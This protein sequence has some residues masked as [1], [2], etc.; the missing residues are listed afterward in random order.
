V[1]VW[2]EK[3]KALE[4]AGKIRVVGIIQEQHPDRCALFMQ[5]H[6]MD[7]PIMVDSLD[8]LETSAVPV[9][10][11]ID[12]A[13]VVYK[14]R[15]RPRDLEAFLSEPPVEF[16]P[17]EPAAKSD[18]DALRRGASSGGVPEM[19]RYADA[20]YLWGG[21]GQIDTAI[22]MYNQ[23][24]AQSD[25]A[26]TQ[27]H[28]GVALLTRF[29]AAGD[30]AD[31]AAAVAHWAAALAMNPN[32]YIWRRRIQQYGP[33]LDKPYSF[34]DWVSRARDEISA[35]GEIPRPLSREPR[36]AELAYPSK[37][38]VSDET[39]APDP[40]PDA[41]INLD[42]RGLIDIDTIVVPTTQAGGSSSRIHVL[43]TPSERLKAHWNNEVDGV[44]VWLNPPQG[45]ELSSQTRVLENPPQEVSREVRT[46]EFEARLDADVLE[47]ATEVTIPGYVLYYVCEDM[48]GECLYLRQAFEVKV[49]VR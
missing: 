41:S 32:Q 46:A 40:D 5:W 37:K 34:Y 39:A 8:L 4:Q 6:E 31:F 25:D 17:V 7:W 13:G 36:G 9:T 15:A 49:P 38:F 28:L 27:F 29:E 12:E 10:V 23:L 18:L 3:T 11:L 22:A 26:T 30:P 1:P 44:Q 14:V 35:R 47:G 19:R 24:L 20:L 21:P 48:D 43:F 42:T 45:V 2:H 16:A 33:R